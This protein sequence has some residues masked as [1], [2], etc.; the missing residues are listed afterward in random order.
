MRR[1]VLSVIVL[2][3]AGIVVGHGVMDYRLINKADSAQANRSGTTSADAPSPDENS[4]MNTLAA[5]NLFGKVAPPEAATP[6][7]ANLPETRL[8][9]TLKG[10][11]SHTD[12]T[13]ASALIE[14]QDRKTQR[15]F[16]NDEVAD[17]ATLVAVNPEGVVLKRNGREEI[18]NFPRI[19]DQGSQQ[20]AA[21]RS[22]QRKITTTAYPPVISDA[23]GSPQKEIE[24]SLKGRMQRL[25]NKISQ[26]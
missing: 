20:H 11:F 23:G 25:R 4:I 3:G 9:L 15:Y 2:L 22:Q 24:V 1:W 19:S 14:G 17:K 5:A 21:S 26:Q 12:P 6:Q 18:L 8:E 13:A 16:I 7:P 10:A